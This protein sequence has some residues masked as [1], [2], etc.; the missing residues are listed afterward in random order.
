ML[1]RGK[2]LPSGHIPPAVSILSNSF[3]LNAV[4]IWQNQPS[5]FH[6]LLPSQPA[7]SLHRALCQ[8]CHEQFPLPFPF[9]LCWF[10]PLPSLWWHSA[11]TILSSLPA[12][13]WPSVAY[14]MKGELSKACQARS[15]I[16]PAFKLHQHSSLSMKLPCFPTADPSVFH[17][18]MQLSCYK[19]GFKSYRLEYF[20]F[21][22]ICFNVM[23]IISV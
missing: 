16:N 1:G 11:G 19:A 23:L 6:S 2:A 13:T 8:L 18:P 10:H 15:T 22:P 5:S 7:S 3:E 12:W 21:P 14:G 9:C 4:T 17:R 20:A